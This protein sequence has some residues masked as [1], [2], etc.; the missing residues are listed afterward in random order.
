[1]SRKCVKLWDLLKRPQ[2]CMVEEAVSALE[3]RPAAVRDMV[4]E[5]R[6]VTDVRTDYVRV[7]AKV[8]AVH[9]ATR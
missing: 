7:G 5:L 9:Y 4:R 1:M 3:V 8:C 2:G 6:K